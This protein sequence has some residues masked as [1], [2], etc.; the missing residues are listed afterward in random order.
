VTAT[1]ILALVAAV[2]PSCMKHAPERLPESF[3]WNPGLAFPLGESS[4]GMNIGSGFDTLL[5]KLDSITGLPAWVHEQVL[6]MQGTMDFDLSTI[7][8]NLDHMNW[9][10][11]R[12]NIFNGFPDRLLAQAY[13]TDPAGNPID[14][15]FADGPMVVS[16]GSVQ[17]SGETI[18][19]A[20]AQRDAFFERDRIEPLLDATAILMR[21][22]IVYP[23]P[24]IALIPFYPSYHFEVR[25]GA[26]IDVTVQF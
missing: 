25:I 20:F 3:A 9:M 7:D 24:D 26:M 8:G 21:A 10:L 19:P 1:V 13:F 18:L 17:G 15:L 23:D 16:P 11:F 5:L 12:V 2:L 22:A 6:T 14:S 4:F